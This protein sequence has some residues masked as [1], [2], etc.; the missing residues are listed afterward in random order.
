MWVT[1]MTA[2]RDA[3]K[4]RLPIDEMLWA[5][6]PSCSGGSRCSLRKR[7]VDLGMPVTEWSGGALQH[8]A[9][10]ETPPLTAELWHHASRAQRHDRA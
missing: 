1:I 3:G 4:G 10:R 8:A 7:K 2:R 6:R 5:C 9:R